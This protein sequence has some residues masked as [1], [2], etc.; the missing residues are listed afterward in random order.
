MAISLLLC[1]SVIMGQAYRLLV[2]VFKFRSF[3]FVKWEWN[4]FIVFVNVFT[5]FVPVFSDNICVEI[6]N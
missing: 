1:I 2:S 5:F 6:R 4:C 3:N